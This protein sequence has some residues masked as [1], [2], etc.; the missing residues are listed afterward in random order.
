VGVVGMAGAEGI[1]NVAVVLAA[2]IG[3]ADQQPDGRAGGHAFEH[4]REDLHRVG[5][6]ALGD[7]ARSARAAPVE[8]G[9]DVGLGQRHSRRAAVN[10]GADGRAVRFAEIGDTK[11]GTEGVSGHEEFYEIRPSKLAR[12][13]APSVP[14]ARWTHETSL[15]RADYRIL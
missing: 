1:G 2:R 11:Q 12:Q 5:L 3:V 6:A 13:Y 4:A 8:F 14:P 9:L 10:H 15:L 7:M